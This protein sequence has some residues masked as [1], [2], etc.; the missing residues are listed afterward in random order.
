MERDKETGRCVKAQGLADHFNEI[1]SPL[2]PTIMK[3]QSLLVWESPIKSA[4]MFVVVHC[5]FW[6]V[7]FLH[8]CTRFSLMT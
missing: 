8:L 4:V 2:E 1:L 5:F 6:Y 3:L 7:K